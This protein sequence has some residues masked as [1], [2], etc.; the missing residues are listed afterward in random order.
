M[1][2]KFDPTKL[3][4]I[5]FKIVKGEIE[6]PYEFDSTVIDNYETNMS[7]NSSFNIEKSIVK[8]NMGFSI[9]T[10]SSSNQKE[11][12]AK[13]DFVYLFKVDNLEEI[14]GEENDDDMIYIKNLLTAIAA[15]SFS[16]SR[17]VL[18]TRLQGTSMKDYILS[19]IDPG[20]LLDEWAES[21]ELS[22]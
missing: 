18:L 7:F 1:S 21:I 12:T 3:K 16:T 22:E 4:I 14:I 17:G 20:N 13:F 2:K 10:A 19:V 11:A 15:I 6:A 5:E 8:A 9:E